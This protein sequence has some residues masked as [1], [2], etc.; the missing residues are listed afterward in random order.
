MDDPKDLDD[1]PEFLLKAAKEP[2]KPPEPPKSAAIPA[3]AAE[4][5]PTPMTTQTQP[6]PKTQPKTAPKPAAKR[7]KGERIGVPPPR[8]RTSISKPSKPAKGPASGSPGPKLLQDLL[9]R[10]AKAAP[11]APAKAK[12]KPAK[13]PKVKPAGEGR[14]DKL[15]AIVALLTRSSGCTGAEVLAATGWPSVSMP[16]QATAAG[17]KL[18]KEKKPGQPTRYWG[19]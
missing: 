11:K 17:L 5:G 14:G 3:S 9:N 19:K 2:R 7:A 16:Q 6:Q 12:A 18:R 13:A 1:I 8:V 10:K 4:K 15:K